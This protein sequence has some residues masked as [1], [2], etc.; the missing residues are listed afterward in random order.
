MVKCTIRVVTT[1]KRKIYIV[2]VTILCSGS[3]MISLNASGIL[4]MNICA[5]RPIAPM[6]SKYMG[7]TG[8]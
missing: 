2:I 7:C 6:H 1:S 4:N 8:Q 3:L 5:F